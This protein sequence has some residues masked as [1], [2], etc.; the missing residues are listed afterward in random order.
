[1]PSCTSGM[2]WLAPPSSHRPDPRE[3]QILDVVARDLVQR[4]VAPRLIVAARHQPV[5]RRRIAQHLVGDRHEVLDLARDRQAASAS[6]PR[7]RVRRDPAAL[8]V[9]AAAAGAWPRRRRLSAPRAALRLPRPAAAG[10]RGLRRRR[11][12]RRSVPIAT[13]VAARQRL[14]ARRPRRSTA[15]CRRRSRGTDRRSRRRAA[16]RHRRLDELEEIASSCACA[17]RS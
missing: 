6:A 3:L 2:F 10:A 7:A 4:A 9:D 15:G 17:R 5:A 11:C 8:G 14:R 12:P 1:M 16:G 13:A